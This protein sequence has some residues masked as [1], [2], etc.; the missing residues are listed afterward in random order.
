M[1]RFDQFC[2]SE[3]AAGQELRLKEELSRLGAWCSFK[4]GRTGNYTKS[5]GGGSEESL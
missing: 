3:K 4:A 2:K 5:R 1:G